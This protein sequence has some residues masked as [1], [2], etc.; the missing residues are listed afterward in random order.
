MSCKIPGKHLRDQIC[1]STY[2]EALVVCLSISSVPA[3]FIFSFFLHIECII[4]SPR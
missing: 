4:M 2:S 1:F 3:S